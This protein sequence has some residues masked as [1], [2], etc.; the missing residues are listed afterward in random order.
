M[1]YEVKDFRFDLINPESL[2]RA[3][4]LKTLLPY[5]EID[6]RK[7]ERWNTKL[8][9]AK[10]TKGLIDGS[11]IPDIAKS[12]SDVMD[13]NRVSAVRNARTSITSCENAGRFASMNQAEEM[14]VVLEK[15]W[16]ATPD[17]RTRDSHQDIDGE[18]VGIHEE[19]SNGLDYPGDPGG[20]PE[21]VYNCRCTMVPVVGRLDVRKALE[22]AKNH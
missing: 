6:G 5:K 14:G 7:E 4:R 10:V 19:F 12:F 18:T 2:K 11:P 13:M 15:Q 20:A 8:I 16:E 3:K 9:S 21:E 22:Y 17:G 1:A